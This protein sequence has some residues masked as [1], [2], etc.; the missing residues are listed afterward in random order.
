MEVQRVNLENAK[1]LKELGFKEWCN[2]CYGTAVRHNGKNI[3]EDEEYEL[4]AEGR[5]SEI[6][7]IEGGELY[8][9][10]WNNRE[11]DANV[12]ACPTQEQVLCWLRNKY[13]TH[14]VGIP[15]I[16]TEGQLWLSEVFEY[17]ETSWRKGLITMVCETYEEAIEKGISKTLNYL[18]KKKK[19]DETL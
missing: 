17:N 15:Y 18:K 14:I 11:E 8:Y 5:E 12:W 19:E 2:Y 3:D 6:E 4:K 10:N 16:T 7:Y 9:F 13:R 1:L